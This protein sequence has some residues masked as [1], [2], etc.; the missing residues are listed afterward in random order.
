M[1]YHLFFTEYKYYPVLT[2]P[3]GSTHISIHEITP[4]PLN[5]LALRGQQTLDSVNEDYTVLSGG[6]TSLAFAGNTWTYKRL[7]SQS[8]S[9]NTRGPTDE[10]VSVSLLAYQSYDGITFTFNVPKAELGSLGRGEVYY[11]NTSAWGACDD[12]DGC[13]SANGRQERRVSCWRSKSRGVKEEV[14]AGRCEELL[15]RPPT[16]RGCETPACV[17]HWVAGGWGTCNVSCGRGVRQREVRCEE[18]ESGVVTEDHLCPSQGKPEAVQ[19]CEELGACQ[20]HWHHGE[21]GACD[22]VCGEG[23]RERGVWCERERGEWPVGG[24]AGAAAEKLKVSEDMCGGGEDSDKPHGMESCHAPQPCSH[25][26][27]ATSDWSK[28][29]AV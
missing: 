26:Q 8:E 16:G 15:E 6:V 28:V 3:P 9:I 14:E 7:P 13:G 19:P 22:V 12:G 24:V 4:S 1:L 20:Y 5:F 29:R 25:F 27:W 10:G 18:V 2:I 21:W 23:R 11:W 17:H